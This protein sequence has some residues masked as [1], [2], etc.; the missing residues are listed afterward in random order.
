MPPGG[1]YTN[2]LCKETL[3]KSCSLQHLLRQSPDHYITPWDYLEKGTHASVNLQRY[4]QSRRTA[5]RRTEW[6]LEVVL[7]SGSP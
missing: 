4:S 3:L 2:C 6:S 5:C 7:Y 1:H